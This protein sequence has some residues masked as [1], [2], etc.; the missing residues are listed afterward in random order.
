VAA[1]FDQITDPINQ[2]E[3][4]DAFSQTKKY[5]LNAAKARG[6]KLDW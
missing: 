5:A 3:M 6:L 2:Q 1:K 4:A